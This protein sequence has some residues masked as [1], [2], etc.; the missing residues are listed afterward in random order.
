MSIRKITHPLIA[1]L[2]CV[3]ATLY[4]WLGHPE[5]VSFAE[6]NQLFL[7]TSDYLAT[8]LAV[9]GGLASYLG[10]A[11]V[12]FFYYIGTGACILGVVL[13]VFYL[14]LTRAIDCVLPRFALLSQSIALCTTLLMWQLLLDE[15]TMLTYPIA[16]LLSVG[17]F[18][19]CRRGGWC[20]QLLASLPLYWL[21]GP[22]FLVQTLLAVLYAWQTRGKHRPLLPSLML[23]GVAV[24]WVV[25]CR[26]YWI[27]QYPWSTVLA[28]IDYH[29]LTPFVCEAP[30]RQYRLLYCLGAWIVLAQLLQWAAGRRSGSWSA[31]T[32]GLC[33]LLLCAA[34]AGTVVWAFTADNPHDRNTHVILEQTYQIRRGD[35]KGLITC[36]EQYRAEH[37]E[38]LQTPLSANAVNL[39]LAMT[40]QM[41]GRMFEFPQSGLQGLLMPNVRDNVSNVTTMEAFWQLGFVNEAMRYA[42]DSQESIPN[43]RKSGRFLRRMAECNIVNGQYEVASKYLALL[44]HT[45]FYRQWAETAQSYLADEARIAAQPEW[46]R[47]RAQ[48]LEADFLFYYPEMSKMLG[49]LVLHRR[50]NRMA[51]DYFMASLLLQGDVHSYVA[52]LPQPPQEGQD[53]F[54]HGYRQYVEYM[55]HNAPADAVTGA[56]ANR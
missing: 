9:A 18:L 20:L 15:N 52:N 13:A 26:T 40:G 35:W 28:G 25:V 43:C 8:R 51:Y 45:L 34:G 49:Q 10:E 21:A 41:A 44:Q 30:V 4:W 27:A 3:S 7:F 6:Q 17:T 11:L 22:A 31:P 42:F 2:L 54:P 33:S 53:P 36:A 50:D 38:A 47:L 29:R 5:L 37:V 46:Q 32:V 16:I 56:S 19:L 39:A 1:L 24:A 14:L 48:R 12:Q 55:Q 23:V